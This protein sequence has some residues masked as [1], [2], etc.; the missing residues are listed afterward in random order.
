MTMVVWM[1]LFAAIMLRQVISSRR[2][3]QAAE[4]IG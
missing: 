2:R 3:T 4:S 1:T